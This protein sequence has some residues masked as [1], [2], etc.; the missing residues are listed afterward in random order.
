MTP[1]QEGAYIRLLAIAW[2]SD[3][4]GLPDDDEQLAALSRLGKG[5]LANGSKQLRSKFVSRNGRLYNERLLA[6]RKKQDEWRKKSEEGG[7]KSWEVRKDKGKMTRKGYQSDSQSDSQRVVSKWLEPK[8]NSSSLSS[9][10][11]L[12][13]DIT[14]T[15]EKN[16]CVLHDPLLEDAR[17]VILYLNEA[18][19]SRFRP[20]GKNVDQVRVRLKEGFTVEDCKAVIDGQ[21]LDPYFLEHPKYFRPSTLFGSKFEGYL[22]AA[23]K[24]RAALEKDPRKLIE[25]MR[26]EAENRRFI[27][28]GEQ[29][30]IEGVSN[31]RLRQ[32]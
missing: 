5:W 25:D 12:V 8:P 27:E 7:K 10:P 16:M 31:G 20:N 29:G 30:L 6:E 28:G 26:A 24:Q 19:G 2:L 1:E 13:T 11:S 18:T 3:D 9:S 17:E 4:C 22:S 14:T 21:K 32:G 15:T 23:P